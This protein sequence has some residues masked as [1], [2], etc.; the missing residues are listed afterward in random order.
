[1]RDTKLILITGM[2]GSGKSTTAQQLARQFKGNGIQH[3]WLHEEVERHPIRDG[4][5]TVGSLHSAEGMAANVADMYARWARLTA[6]IEQSGRVY[7]M[8]GCLY[9]NIIRYFFDADYPLEGI[10]EFYD[11]VTAITASLNPTVV[12]L[13]QADVRATLQRAFQVRGE[14]WQRL[15]LDPASFGYFAKREYQGEASIYAM[16]DEYQAI[17]DAMFERY[18]GNKLKLVTSDGEWDRH[19]RRLTEYFGLS[20]QPQPESIAINPERYVGRYLV[21]P[22]SERAIT[23]KVVDGVLH[24][25]LSWWSN[26]RLIP[27]GS[28]RFEALSFPI[29]FEFGFEDGRRSVKVTGSYDWSLTGKT[30]PEA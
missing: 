9:S 8:E 19:L 25:Q 16:W 5:F 12:F 13:Q 22:G 26:M 11:Q 20:Y 28:D 30:L 15:I 7:V 29:G 3:L 2:S 18:P 24:C 1:M 4:E 27:V 14:S 17:S 10:R 21:E 6:E 23:F